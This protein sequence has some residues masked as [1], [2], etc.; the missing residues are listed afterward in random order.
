MFG[1][2]DGAVCSEEQ[3][4]KGKG[5]IGASRSRIVL[6]IFESELKL[7]DS[8]LFGCSSSSTN[9]ETVSVRSNRLSSVNLFL[10]TFKFEFL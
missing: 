3:L 9:G 6:L 2:I 7:D 4:R 8:A 10:A 5:G 1:I